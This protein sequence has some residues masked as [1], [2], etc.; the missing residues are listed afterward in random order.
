[1]KNLISVVM[2]CLVSSVSFG[3]SMNCDTPG[4][5]DGSPSHLVAVGGG[6]FYC[7]EESG[8][9]VIDFLNFGPGLRL[10]RSQVRIDCTGDNP[11]GTYAVVGGSCSLIGGCEL[12]V[13]ANAD[14]VC[15]IYGF[16]WGAGADFSIG[17]MTIYEKWMSLDSK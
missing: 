11:S 16:N 17:Q 9:R 5:D 13:A 4:I 15:V 2:L 10:A 1:M 14:N 6:R 8:S 7:D 3:L 12:R